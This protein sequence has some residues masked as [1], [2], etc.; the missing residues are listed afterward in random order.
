MGAQGLSRKGLHTT[1][2][3]VAK[4]ILMLDPDDP[5]GVMLCVDYFALRA[6]NYTWLQVRSLRKGEGC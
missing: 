6:H 2:F 3:E 1:A 4:L 5:M